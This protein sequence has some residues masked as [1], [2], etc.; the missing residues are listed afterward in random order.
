MTGSLAGQVAFVTG[1]ARGIGAE[2]ARRLAA[3]GA[4]VALVGL[5]PDR[6]AD[7]AREIGPDAAWWEADV[8]DSGSLSAAVA[9]AADR[10]GG[11]D[12]VMA[13]AG[14]S[15]YGTIRTASVEEFARTIDVNLT[16]VYRTVAAAIDQVVERKGYVLIVASIASYAPLPGGAAYAASKAG[17]DSLAA[18]LRLELARDG[19]TVGSAHPCWIDTDMVR[20]AE[21]A[22]PSFR[23]MRDKLPWPARSVTSLDDCAEA[24][25][26][27]IDRR[28]VKVH[29]PRVA[30]VIAGGRPLIMSPRVQALGR[31]ALATDLDRLD[32]EV[33]A[34]RERKHP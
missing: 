32:R 20:G 23:T 24:L 34:S 31:R 19:V 10:F 7:N 6:L 18:S 16:G 4:R 11:I 15:N 12:I 29:V 28:A 14:I 13:N 3:R 1:A 22:M 30:S 26:D 2:T 8:T 9:G 25:A 21:A 33:T 5:E 17:V 27:A